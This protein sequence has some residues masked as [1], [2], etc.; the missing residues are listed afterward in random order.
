MQPL[1][2]HPGVA[3]VDVGDTGGD[4]EIGRR[5]QKEGGV[6]ERVSPTVSGIQSGVAEGFDAGGEF[7]QRP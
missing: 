4:D 1:L 5:F 3:H 2:H 7:S 6:D